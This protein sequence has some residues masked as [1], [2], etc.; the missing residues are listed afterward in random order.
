[1]SDEITYNLIPTIKDFHE[2]PA[3]IRA[4]VGPVGSGKTTGATWEICYYL[5]HFLYGKYGM[6]KTRWAIVRNTSIELRDTTLRTV[7][8]WFSWGNWKT[9]AMIL[10]LEYPILNDKGLTTGE[11]IEVELLFRACDNEKH[12]R[13]FKS[14]EL[15]GYWIDESIEVSDSTKK[16]LKNRIG[17]YPRKSP[18]RFGI[19]TTNP[20]DVEHTMYSQFAWTTPPPGPIPSGKPLENHAGFWQPPRENEANLRPGYYDD[21][22]RDYADNPDWIEMYVD[23]KPGQL[24]R[25][26]LVYHNFDRRIHVAE[27]PL[28]W[29]S[30]PLYRGWDNSGNTPACIVVCPVSAS[31]LH[32]L[33]EFVTDRENIVDFTN[34]VILTCNQFFPGAKYVD[35]GDP[36]GEARFS[37]REGGFTS[38]ADLQA[39]ECG[40]VV[41]PSEQNFTAR[42]NA[43]DQALM[44]RDGVLIDPVCVRLI[45]G[46][47]G[48]YHYPEMQ[49]MTGVYKKD[50][51][52]N[53]Y[54]HIHDS[55]Q[56]VAV[57]L[58][59][60][61]S[62]E[63]SEDDLYPEEAYEEVY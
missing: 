51:E 7:Q 25:G 42:V 59:R 29:D 28:I 39:S 9:Q 62:P 55:L 13:Q 26:R 34:R 10:G 30:Q 17:R 21:L 47:L 33:R 48:G 11:N 19:E 5:P 32:I 38:N 24:V 50:P 63:V 44:K 43:V 35:Y 56:Y 12:V 31:Q 52:K 37:R 61:A 40:V 45:N 57:R 20:P 18:V 1:M 4:V 60:S 3:Q 36:A 58:Y 16:M 14:L 6:K 54:S 8:E 41:L 2:C 53:K 15:T 49:G 27:E 22:I 46:F 23:G